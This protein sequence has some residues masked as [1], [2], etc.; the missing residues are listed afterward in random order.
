LVQRI[1]NGRKPGT[2][3][4]LAFLFLARWIIDFSGRG[5]SGEHEHSSQ[6]RTFGK[7]HVSSG[8]CC[9]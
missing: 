3:R 2:K 6:Q 1:D 8:F 4:G 7:P 9:W 5:D